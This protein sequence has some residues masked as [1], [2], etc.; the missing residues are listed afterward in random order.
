MYPQPQKPTASWAVS[1]DVW[2]AG[3]GWWSWSPALYWWGL[4][5]STAS[6]CGVLST[7]EMWMC[8]CISRRGTQKIQGSLSTQTILWFIISNYENS[9]KI[10]KQ[11]GVGKEGQLLLQTLLSIGHQVVSN[12]FVH[13]LFCVYIELL[14]LL[15]LSSLSILVNSLYL[16]LQVLLIFFF[17]WFPP[18]TH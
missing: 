18:S 17:S 14:L 5:W 8:W 7:G 9:E 13:R 2:P 1:K 16:N 3:Q 12:C 4:I 10:I 11:M 15:F 6:R